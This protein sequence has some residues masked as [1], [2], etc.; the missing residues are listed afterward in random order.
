[1]NR[2]SSW[3]AVL[4]SL[5]IPI[6]L[7]LMMYLGLSVMLERGVIDDETVVRYLTGHPVSKATLILFFVGVGSLALI[8]TNVFTQFAHAHSIRLESQADDD[9]NQ[10]KSDVD[11]AVDLGQQLVDMPKKYRDHYLWRR[12]HEAL[13]FVHRNGS[14]AGLEDESKYLSE[15]DVDRQHQRYS[16]VRILIWA[17]PMLGFLG[18]VLGISQALGGI[19]VG[20]DN[21][22]QQMMGGLRASLY[23]AFD[24]TALALTLSIVLMFGQFLIDR[25]ESQLLALVDYLTRSE[26]SSHFAMSIETETTA[27]DA[28]QENMLAST[29]KVVEKQ[30]ELWRKTIGTAEVAWIDSIAGVSDQVQQSL[31]T[32]LGNAVNNLGTCLDQ[33]IQ[34]ADK[35]MSHR[36]QQWQVMLSENTRDVRQQQK[37][38]LLQT[39]FIKEIVD[40]MEKVQPIGVST[41]SVVDNVVIEDVN[42][43]LKQ[44]SFDLTAPID[45]EPEPTVEA[46][47]TESDDIESLSESERTDTGHKRIP[48]VPEVIMQVTD[49][50]PAL[51]VFNPKKETDESNDSPDELA[52]SP[53]YLVA[54]QKAGVETK[55]PFPIQVDDQA[56]KAA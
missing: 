53:R 11:L 38:L 16:L 41:K 32:A 52:G 35:S 50:T 34:R 28:L 19:D 54:E 46:K 45:I 14:S 17:T 8:A 6:C 51:S 7:G 56:K 48:L 39:Q 23:I 47:L 2:S 22:F 15:L 55:D 26:L 27:I 40:R 4:P 36:W 5:L 33:S 31:T 44:A 42:P 21:N 37:D 12:L 1:M 20:P 13:H 29:E 25:F 18:T 10:E 43:D 49:E 9:S 3:L 30:A 24:T